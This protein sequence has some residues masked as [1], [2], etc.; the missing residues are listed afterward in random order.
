[1]QVEV[2]TLLGLYLALEEASAD[3]VTLQALADW[4]EEHGNARSAG[5]LR[6]A[7]AGGRTPFRY[8]HS[9]PLRYHYEGWHDGWYWWVTEAELLS[10]GHPRTC[11]LPH[12]L[13]HCLPHSGAYLPATFKQYPTARAAYEALLD[14]WGHNGGHA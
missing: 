10:W 1:M 13:W 4:F 6:W 11:R 5:C 2:Y 7:V 8:H 14:A 9:A 3:A 12:R